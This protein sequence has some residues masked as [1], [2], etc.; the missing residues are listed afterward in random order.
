MEAELEEEEKRKKKKKK[1]I[2]YEPYMDSMDVVSTS[3][4]RYF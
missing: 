4:S 1:K 2:K 3:Q